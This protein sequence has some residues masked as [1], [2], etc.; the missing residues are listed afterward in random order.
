MTGA[1]VLDTESGGEVL[2]APPS[3]LESEGKVGGE[4]EGGR[5]GAS[6]GSESGERSEDE[7]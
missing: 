3:P 5:G 4:S 6:T 1:A 2:D 7:D